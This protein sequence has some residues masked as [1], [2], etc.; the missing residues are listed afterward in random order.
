[1]D[2]LSLSHP[3]RLYT[4]PDAPA[5]A[6]VATTPIRALSPI[7]VY[8]GHLREREEF[9]TTDDPQHQAYAFDVPTPIGYK[10]PA[11]VI[12]SRVF[13]NEA[14]YVRMWCDVM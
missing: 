1:M 13:G 9:H 2:V 12:D 5:R 4:Q 8:R 6:V 11:M 10:G 7:I 14:R 3:C